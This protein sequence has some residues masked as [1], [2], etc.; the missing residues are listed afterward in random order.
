M[1]T[2]GRRRLSIMVVEDDVSL[3]RLYEV[4]MLRWPMQ[5]E[6]VPVESAVSALMMIGRARPDLLI[7]DLNMPGMDGFHLLR[8]LC[9]KPEIASTTIVI[10][11]GMDPAMIAQ[12]GGVPHGIEVLSKPVQLGRLL[13]I[14]HAI[15]EKFQW[16]TA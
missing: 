15:E 5:P 9:S 8:E 16:L 13:Q 12:R 11:T 10:V 1:A 7:M 3:L 14:A 4:T 6:V 2:H